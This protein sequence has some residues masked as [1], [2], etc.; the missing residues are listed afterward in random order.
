MSHATIGIGVSNRHIGDLP[1]GAR[2]GNK[3][4][5]VGDKTAGVGD[6]TAGIAD[7]ALKVMPC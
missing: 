1:I 7:N 4:A 5:G 3:T 2:V 6:K